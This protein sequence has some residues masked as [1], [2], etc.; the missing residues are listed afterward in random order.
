M[1]LVAHSVWDLPGPLPSGK[2]AL[3]TEG[4]IRLGWT[5]QFPL[6]FPPTRYS[7]ALSEND[8]ERETG[9]VLPLAVPMATRNGN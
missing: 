4:R 3:E 1:G 7:V 8:Q 9:M 2:A 5:A 6:A